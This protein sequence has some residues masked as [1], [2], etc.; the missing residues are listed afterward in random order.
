MECKFCKEKI[1]KPEEAVI[2]MG[3]SKDYW[4]TN[5]YMTKTRG[6]IVSD[7]ILS[8]VRLF[9]SSAKIKISSDNW[10]RG[11]IQL[12][13][14]IG[15]GKNL[16]GGIILGIVVLFMTLFIGGIIQGGIVP[17]LIYLVLVLASIGF[18]YSSVF[19]FLNLF[20]HEKMIK[21]TRSV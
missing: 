18:L 2:T 7:K 9:S 11:H 14:S 21:E 4:H 19:Y 15:Y 6:R 17:I 5:C 3:L 20:K 16:I 12:L 8:F 13:L 10:D 1:Q